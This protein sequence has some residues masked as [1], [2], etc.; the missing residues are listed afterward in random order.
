M[1]DRCEAGAVRVASPIDARGERPHVRAHRNQVDAMRVREIPGGREH[2]GEQRLVVQRNIQAMP[3]QRVLDAAR[4]ARR[5]PVVIA[6]Q[7]VSRVD[8]PREERAGRPA[9]PRPRPRGC[10]NRHPSQAI[11]ARSAPSVVDTRDPGAPVEQLRRDL[12]HL[13]RN[14]MPHPDK[15]ENRH[16]RVSVDRDVAIDPGRHGKPHA[17]RQINARA[18]RRR[19]DDLRAI[20]FT[21]DPLRRNQQT[22]FLRW[23]CHAA[24]VPD[25][26]RTPVG[27][28]APGASGLARRPPTSQNNAHF[29]S[30]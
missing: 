18:N 25:E 1:A 19:D 7:S 24:D 4:I 5:I 15:G 21:G 6:E 16:E 22:A 9:G 12:W 14:A 23:P 13:N 28:A 10:R 17:L 30:N 8:A 2:P 20:A 3:K 29:C 26:F 11:A 27:A